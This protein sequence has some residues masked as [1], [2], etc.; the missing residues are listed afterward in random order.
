MCGLLTEVAA[1]V[2]EHGALGAVGF[3]S[4]GFWAQEH[5]LNSCTQLSC[6]KARRIFLDQGSNTRPAVAGGFFTTEPPGKPRHQAD[7]KLHGDGAV[8]TIRH[9]VLHHK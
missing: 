9:R 5:Q 6:L 1:F 2:A 4:C 3:S 7:I 8:I